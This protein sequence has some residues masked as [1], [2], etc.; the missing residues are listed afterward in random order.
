MPRRLIRHNNRIISKQKL[1]FPGVL[2]GMILQFDYKSST[3]YDKKPLVLVLMRE[4][5]RGGASGLMHCLNLN[6]MYESRIQFVAKLINKQVTL[7]ETK[8]SFNKEM[9]NNFT[10]FNMSAY[11]KGKNS[12]KNVFKKILAPRVLSSDDAYRTYSELKMKNLYVCYYN[13]DVLKE[14]RIDE[15]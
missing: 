5:V 10:R 1:T 11:G 12:A 15:D 14:N 4:F 8:D 7:D 9:K 2:P 13:F 3:A 6:Y